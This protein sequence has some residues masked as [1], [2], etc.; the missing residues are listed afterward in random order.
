MEGYLLRDY[1]NWGVE[2]DPGSA[3]G[4]DDTQLDAGVRYPL[5]HLGAFEKGHLEHIGIAL[6]ELAEKLLQAGIPTNAE[7][8]VP[9][10]EDGVAGF[11]LEVGFA[12]AASE[13]TGRNVAD[14]V[15]EVR[16]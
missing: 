12:R 8:V 10:S 3:L 15:D 9:S 13:A 6:F 2:F 1:R 14:V 11:E 7:A 5:R 16:V 4:Q